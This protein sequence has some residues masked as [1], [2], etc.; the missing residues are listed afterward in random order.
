MKTEVM[1]DTELIKVKTKGFGE[2]ARPVVL[3]R[4]EA[5]PPVKDLAFGDTTASINFKDQK[6][7]EEE[8]KPRP[9]T[10]LEAAQQN[11]PE[12]R[13]ARSTLVASMLSPSVKAPVKPED[14]EMADPQQQQTGAPTARAPSGA[15][16]SASADLASMVA[17]AVTQQLGGVDL[18]TQIAVSQ[19][20][21]GLG[22]Q[23]QK[24][25]EDNSALVAGLLDI[26]CKRSGDAEAMAA[27]A[28]KLKSQR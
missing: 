1:W 3:V 16:S 20:I 28:Q 6:K 8:A 7:E 2:K 19:A 13:E 12:R 10:W 21:Q 27:D 11:R 14:V 24:Q 22:L 18:A 4:A 26:V 9:A 25:T 5:A 17:T 23:L 15:A